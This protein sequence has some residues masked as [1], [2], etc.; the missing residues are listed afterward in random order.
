MVS[1]INLM[2]ISNGTSEIHKFN[3]DSF[4]KALAVD[5]HCRT[6]MEKMVIHDEDISIGNTAIPV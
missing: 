4:I 5:K 2:Q 1:N 3:N 6:I